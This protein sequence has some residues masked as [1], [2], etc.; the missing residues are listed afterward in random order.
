M[1]RRTAAVAM[2]VGSVLVGS[3]AAAILTVT[4]PQPT[5]I[6]GLPGAGLITRWGLPVARGLHDLS[7]ASTIGL[8]FVVAV[9]LPRDAR[10]RPRLTEARSRG[11]ATASI[12]AGL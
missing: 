9:L 11:I 3:L 8:L 1:T 4:E 5:L 12:S 7:A 6:Q 10:A 2:L